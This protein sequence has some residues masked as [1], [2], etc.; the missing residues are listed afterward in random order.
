MER[1]A[2]RSTAQCVEDELSAVKR[3][4]AG[5]TTEVR[6]SPSAFVQLLN[7]LE[8]LGDVTPLPL[9]AASPGRLGGAVG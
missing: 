5:E 8:Q 6:I 9:K 7:H 3:G 1:W 4:P 2:I